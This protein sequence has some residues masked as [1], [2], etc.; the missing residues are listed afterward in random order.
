M[1][2]AGQLKPRDPARL[3]DHVAL[4]V[5][6]ATFPP[7]LVDAVL[8]ATGRREQRQRLLP[9]RLVVYYV[10]ALTL[11]PQA[12]YEEVLRSLTEGLAWGPAGPATGRSSGVA[13]SKARARLGRAPLTELFA[14][15][16]RPSRS[17]PPRVPSI[18]ACAS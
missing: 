6:T 10:L 15:A 17:R 12:G 1:P 5:L 7:P 3:T 8:E 14:R 13:I 4:G 18:G 9:A 16:C 2:R 11:F